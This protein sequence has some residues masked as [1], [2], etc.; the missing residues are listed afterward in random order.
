MCACLSLRRFAKIRKVLSFCVSVFLDVAAGVAMN[1]FCCTCLNGDGGGGGGG[2]VLIAF[3]AG[4]APGDAPELELFCCGN[5]SAEVDNVK[6]ADDADDDDDVTLGNVTLG[7]PR[8]SIRVVIAGMLVR[9]KTL[10]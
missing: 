2:G 8:S 5:N 4:G 3:S 1:F 6:A 9:K 7:K 10:A